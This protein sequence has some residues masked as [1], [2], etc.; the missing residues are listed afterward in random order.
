L[1]AV[2]ADDPDFAGTDFPVDPYE[3]SGGS[4][5]TWRKRAAQATLTG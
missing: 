2:D 1:F 3:R 5:I 4:E